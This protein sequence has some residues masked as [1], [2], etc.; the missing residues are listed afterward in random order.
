MERILP[1]KKK[2]TTKVK[3]GDSCG[4]DSEGMALIH[5]C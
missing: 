3:G 2:G 5:K 1:K 4:K